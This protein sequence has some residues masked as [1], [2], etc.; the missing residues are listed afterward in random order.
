M[1]KTSNTAGNKLDKTGG[2]IKGS[3]DISDIL[4]VN[5]K[6]VLDEDNCLEILDNRII[7]NG[8]RNTYYLIGKQYIIVTGPA[9]AGQLVLFINNMA[10]YTDCV[11]AFVSIN[12]D[13]DTEINK[14]ATT[15]QLLKNILVYKDVNYYY[16]FL[17]APN[18]HDNFSVELISNYNVTIDVQEMTESEFNSYVA[19]MTKITE[20]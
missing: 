1:K 6:L 18:F 16:I 14:L 11:P 13:G 9:S 19:S 20:V 3:L 15:T 8:K 12:K 4:T 2:K 10:T 17:Y 5:G 7:K